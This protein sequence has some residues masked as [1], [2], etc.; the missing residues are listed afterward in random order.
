MFERMVWSAREGAHLVHAGEAIAL[1]RSDESESLQQACRRLAVLA[2]ERDLSGAERFF[3]E[4][5]HRASGSKLE[6][7]M[8]GLWR[9][10]ATLLD[11]FC[12][13]VHAIVQGGV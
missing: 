1:S 11:L 12:P 13:A 5:V 4:Q 3:S 9:L 6:V 7:L 10:Q 8:S 2:A